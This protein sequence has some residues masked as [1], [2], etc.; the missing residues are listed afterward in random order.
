MNTLK[1]CIQPISVCLCVCCHVF[2]YV[3]FL[4]I[5]MQFKNRPQVGKMAIK[6][7]PDNDNL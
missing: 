1:L 6:D 5:Y 7:T 4:F 3:K 2:S